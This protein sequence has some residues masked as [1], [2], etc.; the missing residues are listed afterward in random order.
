MVFNP[1]KF[2]VETWLG[3]EKENLLRKTYYVYDSSSR[4]TEEYKARVN[5]NIGGPSLHRSFTYDANGKPIGGTPNIR[6]WTSVFEANQSSN[7]ILNINASLQTSGQFVLGID[8][9]SLSYTYPSGNTEVIVYKSG[10]TV[11]RTVTITY[12]TA[13]KKDINTMVIA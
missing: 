12:L 13:A 8:Y 11:V 2:K 3:L 1:A 9:D 4:V 7:D 5:E 10:T 6:E